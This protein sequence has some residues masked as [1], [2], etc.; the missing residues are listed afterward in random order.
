[1][2]KTSQWRGFRADPD[3]E[4][5][6]NEN[7]PVT[8][9]DRAAQRTVI[10]EIRTEFPDFPTVCGRKQELKMAIW[11]TCLVLTIEL[12]E[13]GQIQ[14]I[15][16]TGMDRID[17]SQ[18]YANRTNY[19]FRAVKTTLLVDCSTSTILDITLLDDTTA[20]FAGWLP[21]AQTESRQPVNYDR[22]QG[23]RL[24]VATG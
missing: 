22:R 3:T 6:T 12:H 13:L 21:T 8:E 20:R 24:V 1:V 19:T 2:V 18:H 10:E 14:A 5:K 7:Y 9:A 15:D 4:L 23:I 17:A 11:S 16:A